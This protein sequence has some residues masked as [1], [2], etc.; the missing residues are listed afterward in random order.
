MYSLFYHF[1][2]FVFLLLLPF[3]LLLRGA[4]FL[5]VYYEYSSS[6]CLL[7][8]TIGTAILMFIYFS[9]FYGQLTGRFGTFNALK[10]RAMFAF[11][12][13]FVYSM[14]GILFFSVNNLKSPNL[15]DEMSSLHPILRLSLSTLVYIDNDLII[16]DASRQTEDYKSMGMKSNQSSLHFKQPSSNYVHAVDIR[17]NG[18]AEIKNRL[19]EAYFRLMGFRT[20]RHIGTADHLHI[21]IKSF[22]NPSAR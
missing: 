12:L 8:S 10:R 20:H 4:T 14:H 7:L 21:S 5:H 9:F 17:T 13:V 18:R 15:K 1:I 6:I 3:A 16:T 19:V 2:K 11:L 22:D